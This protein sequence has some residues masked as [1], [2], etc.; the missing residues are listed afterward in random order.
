[1]AWLIV[2]VLFFAAML[3]GVVVAYRLGP[4]PGIDMQRLTP[5]KKRRLA[6]MLTVTGIVALA[7]VWALS[8]DHV[9]IGIGA[10][11]AVAILPEF[12]LVPL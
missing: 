11:L 12:V 3:L 10:L 2:V 9:A 6:V 5:A 8:T 7:I 1:M 4:R